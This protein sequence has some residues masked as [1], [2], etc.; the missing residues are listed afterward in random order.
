MTSYEVDQ[1]ILSSFLALSLGGYVAISGWL[2]FRFP[3]KY[4]PF[5]NRLRS[6]LLD[7]PKE[8]LVESSRKHGLARVFV[9]SLML[10]GGLFQIVGLIIR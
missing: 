4:I 6:T 7:T 3:H 5:Q 2:M 1:I 8:M 9:G 10:L